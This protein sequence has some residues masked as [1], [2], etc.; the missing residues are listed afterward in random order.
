MSKQLRLG[1]GL[2][3]PLDVVTRRTC[4]LGQTDTGKTSTAVVVVEEAAKAGAHFVVMDP[5]GAWWGLTSSAAGD[6]PGVDC[7]VMGGK[8]GDI[9]L[10]EHAGREVA[11]LVADEGYNLVLDLDG[12]KSWAARQRF[13]AD[14]CS[15]LYERAHSQI[16][17]VMDEAHRLAPQGRLDDSGH[18][19]RCLG[20]VSDVVLLGR[21]RGLG[22]L[23]VCQRP[24]KLHKDVLEMSEVLIAHRV[25]GNNDRKALQGW[26]EEADLDV[27]ALMTEISGLP[28]GV[29]RISAPTM[30]INET[31]TIR[32]KGTFDSSKSIMPGEVA[33][34]PKARAHVDME[35]LR[36]R[37]AATIEKAKADDPA[38]LRRRIRELER[39]LRQR[40]TEHERV[41]VEVERMPEFVTPRIIDLQGLITPL[42]K[43]ASSV[44]DEVARLRAD[45]E[46]STAA[47]PSAPR[48]PSPTAR[49]MAGPARPPVRRTE[50]ARTSGNGRPG[51]QENDLSGPQQRVLDAVAWLEQVGFAQPTKLQVGFIAGY[52][53]G[54]RVGG[55]YGNIL[56]QLRG[57]E[58]IDY[59]SQGQVELTPDGRTVASPPDIEMTTAGLQSAVF[60][61]LQ[62]PERRVLAGI[63]NDYPESISK[64]EAGERAGYQVGDRVGG[65]FG[66]IL[67]RLR[68]LGLVDY[69]TPG[70]VAALPVLFLDR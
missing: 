51:A 26:V 66:N 45:V 70:H 9:P 21:R 28:K 17:V 16:L 61:R 4:V 58:L 37:M 44:A 20:A 36:D 39:E 5:T 19:A 69:P 7:V 42:A 38:E 68:S 14:F 59:P 2:R 33:I 29:A 64:Q 43:Q 65:T 13:T 32:P 25:R 12:L 50:V 49:G 18:A 53:V 48:P 34:E 22:T 6:G 47:K 35:A 60:A 15:E 23:M 46:S 11:H 10:D 3:L 55:T 1:D 40:P 27:R 41:E 63:L 31:H 57:A 52:R 62:E 54:K 67:G 8:H 24:A 30:G 56:G